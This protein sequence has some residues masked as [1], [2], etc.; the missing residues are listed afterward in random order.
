MRS[1]T[2]E[3]LAHLE[4]LHSA[5]LY[6]RRISQDTS[7]IESLLLVADLMDAVHNTPSYIANM[8]CPT[9]EYVKLYYSTFDK[10]HSNIISL[11]GTFNNALTKHA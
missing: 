10:K 5:I 7:K 11:V 9:E 4:V 1:L 2:N 6:A 3:Q 8:Y